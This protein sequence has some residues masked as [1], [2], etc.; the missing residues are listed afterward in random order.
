MGDRISDAEMQQL[1]DRVDSQKQDM[2]QVVQAFR[3]KK[4]L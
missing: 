4:S 3:R 2:K 1:N